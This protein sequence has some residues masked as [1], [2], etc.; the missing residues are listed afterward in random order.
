M[1]TTKAENLHYKEIIDKLTTQ[2]Q[3]YQSGALVSPGSITAAAAAGSPI[4][5]FSAGG[6]GTSSPSTQTAGLNA[7]VSASRRHSGSLRR[8]AQS[9][10]T[11]SSATPPGLPTARGFPPGYK[12]M[13]GPTNTV[14]QA[15][16]AATAAHTAAAAQ[17]LTDATASPAP[18]PPTTYQVMPSD[19]KS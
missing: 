1:E 9:M 2:L 18:N 4:I 12:R 7:L 14:R 15:M 5:E 16:A 3:R 11:L 10:L 17:A 19:Y 8:S 13:T 6:G